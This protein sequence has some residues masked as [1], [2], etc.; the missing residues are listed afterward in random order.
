MVNELARFPIFPADKKQQKEIIDLVDKMLSLN[1][2]FQSIKDEEK[3]DKIK[4]E[5]EVVNDSIDKKVYG[6]YGI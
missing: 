3:S 6:L 4:K 1:K 5:I 2:Q